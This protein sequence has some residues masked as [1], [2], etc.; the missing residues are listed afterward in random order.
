MTIYERE[1]DILTNYTT[2]I[3]KTTKPFL[4]LHTTLNQLKVKTNQHCKNEEKNGT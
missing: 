2:Q 1:A 3:L 4:K